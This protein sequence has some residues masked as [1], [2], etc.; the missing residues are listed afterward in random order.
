MRNL[1]GKGFCIFFSISWHEKI[2]NGA[3]RTSQLLSLHQRDKVAVETIVNFFRTLVGVTCAKLFFL[4]NLKQNWGNCHRVVSFDQKYFH[5]FLLAASGLKV[6]KRC[7]W[8][9]I[10]LQRFFYVL[11]MIW[12]S[13][14][15]I[16]LQKSKVSKNFDLKETNSFIICSTSCFKQPIFIGFK[17]DMNILLKRILKSI[18]VSYVEHFSPYLMTIF[19]NSFFSSFNLIV[20]LTKTNFYL[21][22]GSINWLDMALMKYSW[23]WKLRWSRNKLL[24]NRMIHVRFKQEFDRF[25]WLNYLWCIAERNSCHADVNETL[26][27]PHSSLWSIK[28]N[29]KGLYSSQI[30]NQLLLNWWEKWKKSLWTVKNWWW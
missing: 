29:T 21:Q 24:G 10:P 27:S 28:S 7:F 1:S 5:F 15:F 2:F 3:F 22:I 19:C 20:A 8:L 9:M 26:N 4:H 25:C 14:V 12:K 23:H 13:R 17:K 16:F 18:A 30:D 11:I 6:I